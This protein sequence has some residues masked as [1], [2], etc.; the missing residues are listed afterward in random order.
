MELSTFLT[1]EKEI[2]AKIEQLMKE[3]QALH[4]ELEDLYDAAL[5]DGV[6]WEPVEKKWSKE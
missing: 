6:I 1:K 2:V 5:K 3:Q 4:N